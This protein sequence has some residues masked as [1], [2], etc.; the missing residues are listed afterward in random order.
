[1]ERDTLAVT[2]WF[3]GEVGNEVGVAV[4]VA[5]LEAP[6]AM[7]RTELETPALAAPVAPAP[8]EKEVALQTELSLLTTISV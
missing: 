5:V 7:L 2:V 1:L 4:T 6:G 8:I 3:V